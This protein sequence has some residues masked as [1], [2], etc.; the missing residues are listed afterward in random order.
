[1]QLAPSLRLVHPEILVAGW[2]LL[3]VFAESSIPVVSNVFA[4]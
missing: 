1:V 2:Q 4:M 3:Q